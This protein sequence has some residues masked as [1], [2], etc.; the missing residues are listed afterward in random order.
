MNSKVLHYAVPE[1]SII[2][3]VSTAVKHRSSALVSVNNEHEAQLCSQ[4]L[5]GGIQRCVMKFKSCD[6]EVQ[7]SISDA[8]F[9][10]LPSL[11]DWHQLP[12]GILLQ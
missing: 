10:L 2:S 3:N 9:D 8:K 7:A 1:A 4:L 11:H 6:W 12:S 5:E